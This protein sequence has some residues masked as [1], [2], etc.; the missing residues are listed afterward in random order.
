MVTT[1]AYVARSLGVHIAM[2]SRTHARFSSVVVPRM[3]M[4]RADR[5]T[6]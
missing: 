6:N 4:P 2:R 5:M 1:L 3:G